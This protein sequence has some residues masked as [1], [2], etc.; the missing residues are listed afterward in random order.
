MTAARV[1]VA[2][3]A[4][5]GFI[6]CAAL[7][8]RE[9]ALAGDG[10]ITW[11]SPRWYHDMAA[12]RV[13]ERAGVVGIIAL[14]VGVVCLALALRLALPGAKPDGGQPLELECGNG[15]VTVRAEA[16]ETLVATVVARELRG[17]AVTR[18]RVARR[19]ESLATRTRVTASRPDLVDVHARM[20]AIVG[21]ELTAATGLELERLDLRVEWLVVEG[22]A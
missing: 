10:D 20:R 11:A 18:V 3:A 12:T 17:V 7:M 21:R 16:L 2:L 22:E 8:V 6:L 14:V 4:V 13:W 15:P 19:G 9:A 1:A 5:L